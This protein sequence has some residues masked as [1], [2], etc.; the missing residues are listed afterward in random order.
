M[1]LYYGN[2]SNKTVFGAYTYDAGKPNAVSAVDNPGGLVNT[3]PQAITYTGFNKVDSIHEA[4]R[5][6]RQHLRVR[7]RGLTGTL[8]TRTPTT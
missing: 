4:R 6:Q 8:T 5:P 2:I 3:S 7:R 1:E